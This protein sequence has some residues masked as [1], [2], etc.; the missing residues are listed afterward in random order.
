M[1]TSAVA[2]A[3]T[4]EA[5]GFDAALVENFGD[6]PFFADDVPKS[7]VAAMTYAVAAVAGAV[8]LPLGVNVL[9]NDAI[10]ALAVAA[11]TGAG[12]V[13]VNVLTGTMYT[14]Q[15]PIVGRAAEVARARTA[16]GVDVAIL[17]DVFVKHATPPAGLTLAEATRDTLERGGADAVVVS[18]SGTGRR[19]TM[20]TVR[21]A[22]TAANDEPVY[23]G[24]GA[25]AAT[26]QRYLGVAYGAIVGTSIKRGGVAV[27]PVD[28]KRARAVSE[29]AST[30][31]RDP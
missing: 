16:L 24:S 13:R 9:R 23:V 17:A 1:T 22:C 26:I 15:G 20:A 6:A 7:T 28:L 8:T 11:T 25:T 4:L 10:A 27:K 3:Q 31:R 12:F 19:P 5:A 14:D 29:A 30:R 2:D 18:G 21:A